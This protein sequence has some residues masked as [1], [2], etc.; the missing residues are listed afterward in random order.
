[1]TAVDNCIRDRESGDIFTPTIDAPADKLEMGAVEGA[2]AD[3]EP[4]IT[5]TGICILVEADAG[6]GG[7]V[8]IDAFIGRRD[9]AGDAE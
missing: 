9:A 7:D 3:D 8:F 5:G 4:E 1:M 6:S 2:I